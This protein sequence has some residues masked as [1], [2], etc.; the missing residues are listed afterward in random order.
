M[1]SRSKPERKEHESMMKKIKKIA[2]KGGPERK[3]LVKSNLK[4]I[5]KLKKEHK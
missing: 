1:K 4:K 2:V 5:R 3:P